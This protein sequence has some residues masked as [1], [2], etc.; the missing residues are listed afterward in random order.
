MGTYSLTLILPTRRD[1]AL[2]CQARVSCSLE[3][4]ISVFRVSAC[5]Q[6]PLSNQAT[7]L[8]LSPTPALHFTFSLSLSASPS[9]RL[10]LLS[11]KIKR[12][13]KKQRETGQRQRDAERKVLLLPAVEKRKKNEKQ[14]V[15]QRR[16]LLFSLSL[17]LS[18][19]ACGRGIF[20]GDDDNLLKSCH[21]RRRDWLGHRSKLAAV[22]RVQR[23]KK[24]G[25]RGD[26]TGGMGGQTRNE[27]ERCAHEKK[28]VEE[29]FI[30]FPGVVSR[31]V[32]S[33]L[34]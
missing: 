14:A 29:V 20:A 19:S 27:G 18:L 34:I 13:R 28:Y 30:C 3:I 7:F 24:K 16:L 22:I 12:P 6:P 25:I 9:R 2:Q 31:E 23:V 17:C 1:P 33:L 11:R 4:L 21:G 5:A 10:S 8:P 26:A 32:S 15:A